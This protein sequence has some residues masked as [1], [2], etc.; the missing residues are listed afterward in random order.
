MSEMVKINLSGPIKA[1]RVAESSDETMSSLASNA[2]CEAQTQQLTHAKKALESA[3][4]QFETLCSNFQTE[5]ETKLVD[6]ALDIAKKVLMQKIEAG[7]YK[8]DPIIREALLHIPA[9]QE[10]VVHLHPDD[11]ATCKMASDDG[12][13]KTGSIRFVSDHTIRRAECI[14]ETSQGIVDSDVE[15]H[16]EQ[17]GQALH[18]LRSE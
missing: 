8:I 3:V 13:A 17:I 14:L 4:E 10:V 5:A 18:G 7:N 15:T 2:A 11:L 12:E 16:L 9:R 6:L 1:V